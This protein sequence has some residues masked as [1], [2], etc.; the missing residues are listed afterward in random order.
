MMQIWDPLMGRLVEFQDQ[1][2]KTQRLN[3]LERAVCHLRCVQ[4]MKPLNQED[5]SLLPKNFLHG[6]VF[7]QGPV[8][9]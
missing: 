8:L 3:F 1:V 2:K 9:T 4:T 6:K 5:L 7:K